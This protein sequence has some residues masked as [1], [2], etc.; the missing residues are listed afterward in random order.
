MA[1][2]RKTAFPVAEESDD[3]T[4]VSQ[5]EP[6]RPAPRQKPLK[7][8]WKVWR[9][10]NID[11]PDDYEYVNARTEKEAIAL[12]SF[13]D[14]DDLFANEKPEKNCFIIDQK[15]GSYETFIE[16]KKVHADIPDAKLYDFEG[17]H[18]YYLFREYKADGTSKL[19]AYTRPGKVTISPD[20]LYDAIHWTDSLN[21]VLKTKDIF[22]ME[23]LS[24][25]LILGVLG[26]LILLIIMLA[27]M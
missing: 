14:K 17:T 10:F 27:D 23:K 26:L 5:R 22:A 13:I 25:P 15:N 11:T 9:V 20:K 1:L 16:D 21:K 12:S 7:K 8:G 3:G 19:V 24:T 2:K 4:K 18:M 6:E